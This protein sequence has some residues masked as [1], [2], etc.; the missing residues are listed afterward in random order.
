MN[1]PV[2]FTGKA[3]ES[4]CESDE[5]CDWFRDSATGDQN[6]VCTKE[7]EDDKYGLCMCDKGYVYHT[8]AEMCVDS[9]YYL[10]ISGF[11]SIYRPPTSLKILLKSCSISKVLK[12]LECD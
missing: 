2:L 1:L 10:D 7:S 11:H 12:V 6:F 3:Y 5:D 4:Y 9:E 8:E